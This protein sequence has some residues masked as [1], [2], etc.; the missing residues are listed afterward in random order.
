MQDTTTPVLKRRSLWFAMIGAPVA[1]AVHFYLAWAWV[2]MGC[3]IGVQQSSLL[4][5]NTIHFGVLVLSLVAVVASLLSGWTAYQ[6][7]RKLG[8]DGDDETTLYDRAVARSRFMATVGIAFCA[9]FTTVI[10]FVTLPIFALPPCNA[11]F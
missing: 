3:R 9:I 8:S 4:G 5:V 10:V 2:E 6:L 7:R 1:W 11:T